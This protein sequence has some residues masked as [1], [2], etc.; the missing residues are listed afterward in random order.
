MNEI[1]S[2]ASPTVGTDEVK[3]TRSLT[4]FFLS[5]CFATEAAYDFLENE[6]TVSFSDDVFNIALQPK[7]YFL[8]CFK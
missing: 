4:F 8:F 3:M 7:K 6:P 5:W 2:P 1:P